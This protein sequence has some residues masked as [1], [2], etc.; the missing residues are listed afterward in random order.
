MHLQQSWES[1]Q[2]LE[3]VNLKESIVNN[4]SRESYIIY[5]YFKSGSIKSINSFDKNDQL[6]G[7]QYEYYQDGSIKKQIRYNHGK[8]VKK[9]ISKP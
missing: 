1:L 9:K 5:N 3:N 6:H 8:K 7:L 4:G 2:C